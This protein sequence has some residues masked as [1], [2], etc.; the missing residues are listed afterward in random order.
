MTFDL[1]AHARRPALL[2][3][4]ETLTYADLADRVDALLADLGPARRLILVRGQTSIDLVV[5]LTA[6]L[7]GGHPLLLAPPLRQ[8]QH[9]DLRATYDPDV[10]IDTDVP[11]EH[12]TFV[13]EHTV[14]DLHPELA[15]LLST[16]GSTGCPKLVRL[17]RTAVQSNAAAITTYLEISDADRGILSLPLHYCYGL[18]ILTSHLHAGA[19][20]VVTDWSVLDRCF[21]ELAAE[22]GA[23]GLAGVPHTFD[24]L[25]RLGF[26]DVASLR[27]VTAAGGKLAPERV[28]EL[29]RLGRR[30]GWDFYVMYGQTE[31]TARMAYLP[32]DLAETQPHAIG[33]PIPGGD[34]RI[35]DANDG[36]VGELVYS[37]P[38]VMM[39]YAEAPADLALGHE[40][41]ELR[42]GDLARESAPG[43]FEVVGRKSRFAKVF[44]LRLDLDEI[45]RRLPAPAACVEIDGGLGVISPD[46]DAAE[47]AAELCNIPLWTVRAVVADVPR[48]PSG[49]PDRS[50]AAGLLPVGAVGDA[51]ADTDLCALYAR[52]LG[53]ND[54]SRDDSFVS[55]GADSL[56]Y[57][58]LSVRLGE[59]VDPL[60]RDW[61]R[62]SIADLE[63]LALPARSRRR[64]AVDGVFVDVT[65][66]IR[67]A[68]IVL[69]VATHANLLTVMGGAHALLAVCGY[70][71]ARFLPPGRDA[72]RGLLRCARQ[73]AVPSAAWIAAMAVLGIYA[74][75]TAVFLNGAFG[76]DRWT[77][78]WQFWFLEAAIW[79]LV[80]VGLA[81]TIGPLRRWNEH[82]PFTA[83]LLL[84]AA[85]ATLRYALVGVDTDSV[86]PE[87]Y[88]V[89]V[90]AWFFALGWAAARA[91]RAWHRLVVSAVAAVLLFGFFGDVRRELVIWGAVAALLWA[92]PVRLPRI[93]AAVCSAVA[94][95]SLAIYLTHWQVYPH[96]EDR[97]PLAATVLSILVGLAYHRLCGVV[98]RRFAVVRRWVALDV[99]RRVQGST[100]QHRDRQDI[101]QQEHRDRR[102]QWPV[103]RRPGKVREAQR[104]AG[105]V[106]ADDPHQQREDRPGHT[107][108]PRLPHRNGQVVQAGHEADR[109]HEHGRPVHTL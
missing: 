30:R 38:N 26:P 37:G 99:D 28:T 89:L 6:A 62:R 54:V 98:S 57:V 79:S 82:R 107:Q 68:A 93:A 81:L 48:L 7:V 43:V 39:G 51:S 103:D 102:R 12:I 21:W 95:A 52:L 101:E 33:G 85:T 63:R 31:A 13:R 75:T 108:P 4:D 72:A 47:R 70:N 2:A 109:E 16:S 66:L 74:P 105:D 69:I 100:D 8:G 83:A 90:V 77:V 71:A 73:V 35:A 84:L 49:K 1:R 5:A 80:A 60:P 20:V 11:G 41:A 56:S 34:I 42:T 76:S 64:N 22:H 27:Y 97:W 53:R 9:D 3:A 10:V 17:S 94:A 96:L 46:P 91:E 55:L 32:P 106:A 61:H 65:V 104:P 23:T 19:A 88:S 25:N 45:E 67:A 86:L 87:R 15:L 50:A 58:E 14:H 29:T 18:S 44:G 36:G 40:V 59:L 92:P 78:D 24:Q